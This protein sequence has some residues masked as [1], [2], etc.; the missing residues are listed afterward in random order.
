MVNSRKTRGNN[1]KSLPFYTES[2]HII[3]RCFGGSDSDNNLVLLTGREHF[4]AHALLLKIRKHSIKLAM[5]FNRMSNSGGYN[6][7]NSRVYEWARKTHSV[8]VSFFM[9]KFHEDNKESMLESLRLRHLNHPVK[10]STKDKISKSLHDY[11]TRN[12]ISEEN[13]EKR[14]KSQI[15]RHKINPD[16]QETKDKRKNTIR[17]SKGVPVYML[18]SEGIVV[19]EFS[20]AAEAIEFVGEGFPQP[21][22]TCCKRHLANPE[23]L[24]RS[25]G[26]YWKYK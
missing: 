6:Y 7:G 5:A 20:S 11:Y 16:S 12:P 1:K 21:I 3:P 4:I 2:H 17:K 14:S 8:N 10:D 13:R 22:Y 26:Y 18:D 23:R 15:L 25:Y 24:Y 19:G 9:K